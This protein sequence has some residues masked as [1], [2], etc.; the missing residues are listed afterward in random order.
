M[1]TARRLMAVVRSTCCI[2]ESMVAVEVECRA[3]VVDRR[4]FEL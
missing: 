1:R 2:I 4:R 3:S